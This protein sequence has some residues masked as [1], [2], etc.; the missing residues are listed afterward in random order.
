MKLDPDVCYQALLTR[1]ARFDGCFF[2]GV[3]TTGIYC[4]PVCPVKTPR[5]Q[6]CSFFPSAAAAES[7]GFR[8]CLRCR[9]ELAPGN[10]SIE[11]NT[12]LAHRA[13]S[14][15][16]DGILE[17]LRLSGLADRLG[18][19]DRHLRRVFRTELGASPIRFAQTQRLL[20]AKRL[21]TD[22]SLSITDVAIASGFSSLRRFNAL[23]KEHYRMSPTSLRRKAGDSEGSDAITL[24]L[25][26]R[27]PLAWEELIAFL[28]TRAIE[29]V[30]S[31]AEGRYRRSVGVEAG[32]RLHCGWIE[33]FLNHRRPVL[34]V[35]MD[36]ALVRVIPQILVGV[37]RLFDLSAHPI[38]I[39]SVLG[40]L[41]QD[42]P[43]LRVPGAFDGFETAVRAI[44]GQQITVKAASTVAGRFA[45][46]LGERVQTPF[47]EI[48]HLFPRPRRIAECSVSKIAELGIVS[49]RAKSIIALARAVADGALCLEPGGDV[50]ETLKALMN[51]PGVGVWTAQYVAMRALAWPD[52]FPHT[53]YGVMKAMKE[54]SPAK[55]LAAAEKWRPWRAYAAMHLWTSLKGR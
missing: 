33:V 16:E 39:A 44:L 43:G 20:L 26:Y 7:A 35:R 30:E 6:S 5:R 46:A 40:V 24:Q 41:A 32:G 27:P 28:G 53:D 21:L 12:R 45:E 38:E 11:A 54:T 1:D 4:R 10:S 18:V 31:I 17:E 42:R 22:T 55:V 52:A 15:I 36:G 29:A 19:T 8:P 50:E 2:A 3:A 51:L 37:K 49:Q 13:A 25:G 34:V 14:L 23:M 47:Q 48:R 9:P